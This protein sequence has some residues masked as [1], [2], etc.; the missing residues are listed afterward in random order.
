MKKRILILLVLSLAVFTACQ[1]KVT[2]PSTT[3]APTTTKPTTTAAPT[4]PAPTTEK[5]TEAPKEVTYYVAGNFNGY[6]PNDPAYALAPIEGAEGQYS[7]AVSLTAELRDPTYD[8]HWYKITDGTWDNSWGT[9]NYEL[10]PAPVKHTENNEPIGLGSIWID[11]DGDYTIIFDQANLKIYD[12]S[13]VKE[14][15]PRIYGDFNTAINKGTDWSFSDSDAILLEEGEGGVY[16]AEVKL[17][18][19]SGEGEGYSMA[20]LIK[21][22]YSAW[23][24]WHGWG[25]IE[26]YKF[27]GSP[28]GMGGVSY[29]KPET[30]TTY[31]F[32]YDSQTHIT[33]VTTK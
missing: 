21:I 9:D 26:Q 18:A 20:V 19:Y 10:Q 13:M 5:P 33:T 2:E 7:V 14:L 32:S 25:A 12:N 1:A 16:T 28:A 24:P 17:P 23:L 11:Q 29:L 4:T 31:L 27:D 6:V 22:Q 15:S 3:T 8:G 30:E